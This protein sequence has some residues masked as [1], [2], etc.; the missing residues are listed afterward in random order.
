MFSGW[1]IGPS[2]TIHDH[3]AFVNFTSYLEDAHDGEHIPFYF[4]IFT[5]EIKCKT[6][7]AT[8][9]QKP[10]CDFIL[11]CM[12]LLLFLVFV[13]VPFTCFFCLHIWTSG[14]LKIYWAHLP[15][16][17]QLKHIYFAVHLKLPP[18]ISYKALSHMQI[19]KKLTCCY[20]AVVF[21]WIWRQ[22]SKSETKKYWFELSSYHPMTAAC[23]SNSEM[24]RFTLLWMC[25]DH[26]EVTA[27]FKR[28]Q[29][30]CSIYSLFLE[31][32]SGTVHQC[33]LALN[34][35]KALY[36]KHVSHRNG[37]SRSPIANSEVLLH[38]IDCSGNEIDYSWLD[39]LL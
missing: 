3:G 24:P 32:F 37:A 15:L 10:P 22:W 19:W 31:V 28:K 7:H 12:W 13:F 34:S 2:T 39:L 36:G 8:A 38:G 20:V 35:Y 11:H 18:Y 27:F 4:L 21:F 5:G 33:L 30:L 25:C 9:V 1:Q 26:V 29:L 17:F 14:L 6:G 23:I 16:F